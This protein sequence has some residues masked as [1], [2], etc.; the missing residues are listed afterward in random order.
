MRQYNNSES[1]QSFYSDHDRRMNRGGKPK[2]KR[3]RLNSMSNLTPIKD[4]LFEAQ[5]SAFGDKQGSLNIPLLD[6]SYD[7]DG[8][9]FS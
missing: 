8:I 3:S 7:S 1:E 2:G 5:H 6:H 9:N 4:S